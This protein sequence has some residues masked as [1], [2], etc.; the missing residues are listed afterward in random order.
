LSPVAIYFRYGPKQFG[1][2]ETL[3]SES[4]LLAPE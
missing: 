2:V 4:K 3:H 1:F